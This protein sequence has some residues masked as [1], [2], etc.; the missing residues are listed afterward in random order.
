M[1]LVRTAASEGVRTLTLDH[2]PSNAVD[3]SLMV[4]F[5][6]L[7]PTAN[8]DWGSKV[9]VLESAIEGVFSMGA[10]PDAKPAPQEPYDS[11]GVPNSEDALTRM[12]LRTLWDFKWPIIA[13]VQ[14][15]AVGEGLLLACLCDVVVAGESAAL[16][17]TGANHGVIAG[18]SILRRCL[19]EQAMRY[20][21]LSGRLVEARDVKA[22]GC[23]MIIVPDA[24][25]DGV[26]AGIARDIA[27]KD[28]HLLRHL[29][30][31]LTEGE[32]GDPLGGYAAEQRYTALVSAKTR[33]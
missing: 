24:E 6:Q 2:A 25:V 5:I 27:A 18:A 7:A 12:F 23:G 31:S 17:L 15:A 14:G 10:D 9:V 11:F 22:L 33:P 28:P 8:H 20:L 29:K 30:A 26:T 1:A 16:G 13:K 4:D 3:H 19:S 32:P 21:I